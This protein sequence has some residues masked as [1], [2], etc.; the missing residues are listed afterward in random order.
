MFSFFFFFKG[1]FFLQEG[2]GLAK[3]K[4]SS[5]IKLQRA[6]LDPRRRAVGSWWKELPAINPGKTRSRWPLE[7]RAGRLAPSV[8]VKVGHLPEIPPGRKKME[9]MAPAVPFSTLRYHDFKILEHGDQELIQD[10]CK[11]AP[12]L[13]KN[14]PK[15]KHKN[16]HPIHSQ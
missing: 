10:L 1:R 3:A 9:Q 6:N 12:H 5:V 15:T 16:H 4:P 2:D 11:I 13:H 14:F 8:R 7:A